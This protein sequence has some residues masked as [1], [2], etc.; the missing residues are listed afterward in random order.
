MESFGCGNLHKEKDWRQ[1]WRDFVRWCFQAFPKQFVDS[2]SYF[3][4]LERKTFKMIYMKIK[5]LI[6]IEWTFNKLLNKLVASGYWQISL[7]S[8]IYRAWTVNSQWNMK[9]FYTSDIKI[10]L[11][12]KKRNGSKSFIYCKKNSS[13]PAKFYKALSIVK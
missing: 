8:Q 4:L 5:I 11:T 1:K 13:W 12:S 7:N 10:A 9:K 2:H 6:D 3:L